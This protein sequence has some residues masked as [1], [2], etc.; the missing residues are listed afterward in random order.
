MIA[1]S[2]RPAKL[3]LFGGGRLLAVLIAVVVFCGGLIGLGANADR[4]AREREQA[5]AANALQGIIREAADQVSDQANWD[6]ALE[7]ASN[8]M[9]LAWVVENV[10]SVLSQATASSA[11][12]AGSTS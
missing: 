6:A 9:D 4:L 11:T 1:V 10:G 12:T 3:R 5:Q 8:K 7:H 2:P